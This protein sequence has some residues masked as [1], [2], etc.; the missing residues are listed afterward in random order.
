[1]SFMSGIDVTKDSLPSWTFLSNHGHVLVCL[2][3]NPD[4]RLAEVARMVGIGERAIHR[5]VHE[6]IEAGYLSATKV[7]RRSIYEVDLNIPLRHPLEAG[8]DV[9]AIIGPLVAPISGD[10]Q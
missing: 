1:M 7:G 5:I 4:T 2:A 3:R 6:L 8:N 9:G 10:A